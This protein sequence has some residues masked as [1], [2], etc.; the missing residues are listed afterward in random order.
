MKL[1]VIPKIFHLQ[2]HVIIPDQA[3]GYS[4]DVLPYHIEGWGTEW[5]T[6][7]PVAG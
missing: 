7:P 3:G 2:Y 4:G 1:F 6:A 5:A